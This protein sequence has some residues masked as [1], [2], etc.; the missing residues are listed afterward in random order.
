MTND[1]EL[2][3]VSG[4]LEIRRDCIELSVRGPGRARGQSFASLSQLALTEII[5]SVYEVQFMR[6]VGALEEL[7]KPLTLSS[8]IARKIEDH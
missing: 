1:V 8:G 2:L 5:R 6:D 7:T 4:R 3:I